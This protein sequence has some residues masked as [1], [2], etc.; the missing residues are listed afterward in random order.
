[1]TSVRRGPWL[2]SSVAMLRSDLL[3]SL[4]LGMAAAFGFW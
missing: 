3:S 1:M 4:N 2:A